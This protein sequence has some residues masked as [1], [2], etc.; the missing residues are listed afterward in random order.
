MVFDVEE[1]KYEPGKNEISGYL[2]LKGL[3][4]IH[5]FRMK[6]FLF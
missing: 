2:E 6:G 5:D 1:R 3:S 4:S